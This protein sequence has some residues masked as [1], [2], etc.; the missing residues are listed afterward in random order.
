MT[1]YSLCV[2]WGDVGWGYQGSGSL[3][4][5][6]VVLCRYYFGQKSCTL[7]VVTVETLQFEVQLILL[8]TF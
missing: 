8:I 4:G 6:P 1:G 7:D 3:F 2:G 5:F